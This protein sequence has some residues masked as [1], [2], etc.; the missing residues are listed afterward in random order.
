M[1]TDAQG[2]NDYVVEQGDCLES[3]AYRHG[4]FWQTIWDHP[5]NATLKAKRENPNLLCP[6]DVV[7]IPDKAAKFESGATE[8]KHRFVRKGVPSKLRLRILDDDVPR[9]DERYT[10]VIDGKLL[11]GVTDRDGRIE[12]SIDPDARSGKL[13]VGENQDEYPLCLG[14][15]DPVEE[16]S[17]VQARLNNLGFDCGPVDGLLNERTHAALKRFQQAQG[18]EPSEKPDAVTREKL[19]EFYGC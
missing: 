13:L 14:H 7:F 15:L 5:N 12:H 11:T 6:G 17:G 16:I 10:L 18:L 9:A 4:L 19:K 8:M 3:I 1:A 2:T